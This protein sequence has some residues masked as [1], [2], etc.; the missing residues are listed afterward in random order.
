EIAGHRLPARYV[1]GLRRYRYGPA[2]FKV[3]WALSEPIP[4]RDDAC[5]QAATVHLGG[6]LEAIA[7]AE[8]AVSAGVPADEPFVLVAQPTIVD[9]TRAPV[10]CH[11]AWAYAHVPHGWP[12]DETSRIEGAIERVAPGFRDTILGRSVLTPADL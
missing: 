3:D 6:T 4:W 10:G 12:K 5:R 8:A 7:A 11:V 9:P 2:A 1:R